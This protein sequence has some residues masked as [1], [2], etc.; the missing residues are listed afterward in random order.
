MRFFVLKIKL[1]AFYVKD[2]PVVDVTDESSKEGQIYAYAYHICRG[3][4]ACSGTASAW[5][6]PTG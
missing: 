6:L 1:P 3:P 4:A 2:E 5:A